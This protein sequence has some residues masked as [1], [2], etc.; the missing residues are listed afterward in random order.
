MDIYEKNRCFL[1]QGNIKREISW[2]GF[3]LNQGEFYLCEK[4]EKK[5]EKIRGEKCSLCSRPMEK[6][7]AKFKK[8]AICYDC[9][10]WEKEEK[11]RGVLEKNISLYVYNEFMAELIARFKYR[12]DYVLAK[13]FAADIKGVL[14]RNEFDL[15][16]P[17]PLS[18]ERLF[19][20]G[21]N[22]AEALAREAGMHPVSILSRI[23]SEKQAKKS[24]QERIHLPEVFSVTNPIQVKE[25]TVLLIDDIYT[26]GSTLRHAAYVLKKAGAKRVQSLTIAR[27]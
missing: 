4:C 6:L 2:V 20:R 16:V 3:F 15:I 25:K 5:L 12:G 22:Q 21:F 7:P 13:I 9:Y 24:R 1:C 8:E 23:H 26:T 14:Q 19:E 10:L 11:W 17:I 18:N 27:G